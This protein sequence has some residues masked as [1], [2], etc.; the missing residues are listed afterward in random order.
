MHEVRRAA[1]YPYFDNGGL[2]MAFA[3]RGGRISPD[4]LASEN[5]MLAFERAVAL[6]Y[7]YLETDAHTTRDGVLLAFHD[8]T[9]RRTTGSDGSLHDL[10]YDDVRP[11]RIGGAEPIPLMHELLS[12]WPDVRI[13][14]DA[15]STACVAPLAAVIAEHRAWDRVCVASFSPRRLHQ[16]R[17]ALGPRVATAY[18]APGVAAMRFLPTGP[19]RRVCLGRGGLVAQVPMRTNG[20]EVVTPSF[21]AHAHDLGKQVHVWTIDTEPE[22]G[23]VLDLGV[24]AVMT[25]RL[26]VLRDV[27]CARGIWTGER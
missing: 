14:I 4:G 8:A 11:L 17:Q 24:D 22:I 18:A 1:E 15:K 27:F 2:P 5:T 3:H 6:G 16:L 7:R 13:N 12:T 10:T 26:D 21:V 20:I 19:L 25:D 23:R 9:V